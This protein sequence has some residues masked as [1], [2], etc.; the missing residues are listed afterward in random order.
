MDVVDLDDA[1]GG[2][3]Q[4]ASNLVFLNIQK[5]EWLR[6]R[7]GEERT[8]YW[9]RGLRGFGVRVY[10]TGR[11]VFTFRYTLHGELHRRSLGVYRNARGVV[12]GEVS[13]S[14]ARAEAE[15][16]ISEARSGRDPSSAS[17]C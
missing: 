4:K 15:R 7:R 12:G 5:L 10:P 11:K 17:R 1:V 9:D 8:D 2:G 6:T 3:R 13:Y 16:I 14:D